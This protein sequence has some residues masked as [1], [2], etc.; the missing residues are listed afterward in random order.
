MLM[1]QVP[2]LTPRERAYALATKAALHDSPDDVLVA[3]GSAGSIAAYANDPRNKNLIIN[4]RYVPNE[5]W[6]G[7]FRQKNYDGG[8]QCYLVL[9]RMLSHL[10]LFYVS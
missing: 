4:A 2:N 10:F 1:S 9:T 6:N 3:I 7:G 8:P 5:K